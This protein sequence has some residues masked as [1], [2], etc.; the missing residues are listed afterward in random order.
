MFRMFQYVTSFIGLL[1]VIIVTTSI[2]MP[3]MISATGQLGNVTTCEG[4]RTL[5]TDSRILDRVGVLSSSER[6]NLAAFIKDTYSSKCID[7]GIMIVND[8]KGLD[9]FSYSTAA[10]DTVGLGGHNDTGLLMT[11]DTKSRQYFVETGYGLESCMPDG[12]IGTT[13][14]E[15]MLYPILDDFAGK[16]GG[17]GQG[18]TMKASGYGTPIVETLRTLTDDCNG[19][20][21]NLEGN[22]MLQPLTMMAGLMPI[23]IAGVIM[24]LMISMI[25]NP[26]TRF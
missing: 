13:A 26:G 14:R 6:A 8:T 12:K 24:M 25:G 11:I 19:N 9:L 18:G 4:M 7:V 21:A 23:L 20:P 3:V 15:K 1:V 16:T 10:F 22:L 5:D 17:G 2:V